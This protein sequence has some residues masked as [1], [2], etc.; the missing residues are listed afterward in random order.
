VA[1]PDVPLAQLILPE[2]RQNGAF[3]PAENAKDAAT[4]NRMEEV[5]VRKGQ[6]LNL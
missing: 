4:A 6:S 5:N 1:H 3:W 2:D